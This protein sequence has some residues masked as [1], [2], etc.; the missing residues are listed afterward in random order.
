LILSY[1]LNRRMFIEIDQFEIN[2]GHLLE[3]LATCTTWISIHDR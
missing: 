3:L 2:F 1:A